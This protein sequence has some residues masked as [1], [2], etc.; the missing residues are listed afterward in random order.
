MSED[1]AKMV[2]DRLYPT[3]SNGLRAANDVAPWNIAYTAATKALAMKAARS[4]G[5]RP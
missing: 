1:I 2:A 3:L 5:A 4:D